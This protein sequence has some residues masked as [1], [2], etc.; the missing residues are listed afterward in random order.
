MGPRI[1]KFRQSRK[2]TQVIIASFLLWKVRMSPFLK[3]HHVHL[4][5]ELCLSEKLHS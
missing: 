1:D 5:G 4:L 3:M 2:T